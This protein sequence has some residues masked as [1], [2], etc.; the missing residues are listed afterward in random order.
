VYLKHNK[1]RYFFVL[2]MLVIT[3][4]WNTT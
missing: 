3:R 2:N 4:I 1:A